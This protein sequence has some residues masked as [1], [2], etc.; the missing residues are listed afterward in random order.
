MKSPSLCF[1]TAL[2]VT[3]L[4]AASLAWWLRGRY[5]QPE[6]PAN[7]QPVAVEK[8]NHRQEKPKQEHAEEQKHAREHERAQEEFQPIITV[9]AQAPGMTPME[10]EALVALPLERH[11]QGAP[12]IRCVRS[13]SRQGVCTVWV[14][15]EPEA[16][17][18]ESRQRV[19]E[20]L[21]R[22]E[23]P[24]NV[25]PVL[26]PT[27][28]S[29]RDIL[30]IGLRSTVNPQTAE[31]RTSHAMDLRTLAEEVLR[32]RL[33]AIPGVNQ[34]VATGGIR[35]QVQVELDRDS[36]FK[37][38]VSLPQVE[39]ALKENVVAGAGGVLRSGNKELLVRV[40]ARSMSL[41]DLE[42][43]VLTVRDGVPVKIKDVAN[44]R[45][46]KSARHGTGAIWTR[47][48]AGAQD[49]PA[50]ILTIL[51]APSTD[52][53]KIDRILGELQ[54]VLPREV[55]IERQ[56][57]TPKDISVS[58]QLSPGINR[59]Q[60]DRVYRH[61]EK[62]L[63]DVPEIQSVWRRANSVETTES[64]GWSDDPIMFLALQRKEGRGRALI[65]ADIRKRIAAIP[66]IMASLGPPV[67][68]RLG[69]TGRYAQIAVQV[70][71][72]DP[73][74]LQRTARE[75]Q[76]RVSTIPGVFDLLIEPTGNSAQMQIQVKKD[77]A[78]LYGVT[79]EDLA[80]VVEMALQGR[81]IGEVLHESRRL[82]LVIMYDDKLRHSPEE[83][84]KLM[85]ETESGEAIPL[86]NLTE[87]HVTEGPAI[88]YRQNMQRRIVVSCNVQD[89]D[90]AAVLT[91][92][93]QALKPV[94]E[95]LPPGY[96]IEYTGGES[97][98]GS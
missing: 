18:F 86:N 16:N 69:C 34:V 57:F 19:A 62:E 96:L 67:S 10:I 2:I 84:G 40:R 92:I 90:R 22:V 31:E 37:F 52:S 91:D 42:D 81:V 72:P 60:R 14:D 29:E 48:G 64:L 4:I 59:D 98:P 68:R 53:S 12:G 44:V 89:R 66:G 3:A 74:D 65:L 51:K 88:V 41:Q 45:L 63:K 24:P 49:G 39:E 80:M 32:N 7:N 30:L 87:M 94:E 55:K 11:I 76:R 71:G 56:S 46:G 20:R 13:A 73:Q 1:A 23:L 21:Q 25:S 78:S 82:D 79:E 95:K 28:F 17:I 61:V 43:T 33:L 35:K 8:E 9:L 83:I 77:R 27:S 85:V 58:L 70:F 50:V 38:G 6:L 93:R 97:A 26:A 54:P 36:L 15:L 75:I 5:Q 47:E